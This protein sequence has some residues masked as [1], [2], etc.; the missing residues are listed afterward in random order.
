MV[1]A[2]MGAAGA[3]KTTVGRLLSQELG[4]AFLDGDSVH[5]SENIAKMSHGM[6]LTEDDRRPWLEALRK[7]VLRCVDEHIDAVLAC[8]LLTQR[9]RAVVLAGDRAQ[10]KLAYLQAPRALLGER[11]AHRTGHFA[12]IALL[13]SQLV[14]LD[15]PADALILDATQTPQQLVHTIRSTWHL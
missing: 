7:W 2:L 6:P 12:G 4:W 14:L 3:G 11:L 8:S 1:I 5:P 10:I 9:Y 15:P 13:D